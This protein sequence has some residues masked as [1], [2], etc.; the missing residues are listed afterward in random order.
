[1]QTSVCL[2]KYVNA[3]G[4]E[5]FLFE[6]GAEMLVE[7][8][9]L[10]RDLGFFSARKGGKFCINGVTGPD[11]DNT[12]VNNNT[13]TNLMARENLRFAAETMSRPSGREPEA[14]NALIQEDRAPAE[15]GGGMETGGRKHW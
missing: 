10:W 7:T 8:A 3:T 12:V 9:R 15:R 4:D 2:R 6:C 14:L 13:Y 5:E 11:E 1:M